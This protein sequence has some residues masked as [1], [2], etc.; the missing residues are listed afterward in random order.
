MRCFQL[1]LSKKNKNC[2]DEYTH[3]KHFAQNENSIILTQQAKQI[4]ANTTELMKVIYCSVHVLIFK[5][6]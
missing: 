2:F 5:G 6:N 3:V 4:Y 1:D